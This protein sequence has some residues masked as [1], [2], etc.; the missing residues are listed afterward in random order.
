MAGRLRNGHRVVVGWTSNTS[1]PGIF[2]LPP[3]LNVVFDV[4]SKR[5][6]AASQKLRVVRISMSRRCSRLQA[7]DKKR[8]KRIFASAEPVLWCDVVCVA[9]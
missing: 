5:A 8:R 2:R 4:G 3:N 1:W 9:A 7:A 6:I